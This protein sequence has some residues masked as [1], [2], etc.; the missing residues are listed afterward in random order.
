MD[1]AE[2]AAP[3]GWLRCPTPVSSHRP[4]ISHQISK[5]T[6][7]ARQRDLYHK[8]FACANSG[9]QQAR[10]G[11]LL[12]ERLL[13]EEEP[14]PILGPVAWPMPPDAQIPPRAASSH[15]RTASDG[16]RT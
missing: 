12:R 11:Q 16:A 3:G 4:L 6:C 13:E 1:P 10:F 15:P 2:S 7:R 8:C 9:L 5:E 14:A